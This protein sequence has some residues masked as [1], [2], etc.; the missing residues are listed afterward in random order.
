EGN[1]QA[2]ERL[3]TFKTGLLKPLEM[4]TN[5]VVKP[6]TAY[7]KGRVLDVKEEYYR[8]EWYSVIREGSQMRIIGIR[9]FTFF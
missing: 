3:R 6:L 5:H 2:A 4:P 8:I 9:F 1:P 7:S